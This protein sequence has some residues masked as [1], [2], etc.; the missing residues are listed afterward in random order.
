TARYEMREVPLVEALDEEMG[1]GFSGP[2]E[3]SPLLEGLG[4]QAIPGEELGS[5]WGAKEVFLLSRLESLPADGSAPLVLTEKDVRHLSRKVP[6]ELPDAY[7][8]AVTLDAASSASLDAGDYR[9]LL[10]D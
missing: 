8:I 3:S 10:K 9:L 2:A 6:L 1:V 4:L 5:N 7:A